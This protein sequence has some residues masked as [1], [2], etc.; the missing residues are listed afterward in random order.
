MVVSTVRTA[1]PGD[2][3]RDGEIREDLLGEPRFGTNHMEIYGDIVPNAKVLLWG[4][5]WCV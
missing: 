1:K 3:T 2:I 4:Q 5:V